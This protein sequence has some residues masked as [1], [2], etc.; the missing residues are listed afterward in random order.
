MGPG[1]FGALRPDSLEVVDPSAGTPA[2]VV[3]STAFGSRMRVELQILADGSR[4]EAEV[5]SMGLATS[6]PPGTVVGVRVRP[7]T[8]H[9]WRA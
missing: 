4:V 5:A 3:T 6:L 1:A 2:K 8:G 9:G 7:D